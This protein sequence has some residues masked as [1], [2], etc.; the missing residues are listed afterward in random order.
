MFHSYVH[1][2]LVLCFGFSF[3]VGLPSWVGM[4]L[5]VSPD[6]SVFLVLG[7]EYLVCSCQMGVPPL[8]MVGGIVIQVGLFLAFGVYIPV[9]ARA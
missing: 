2:T 9:G 3:Q 5:P 8:V 1:P 4:A 6:L 7:A